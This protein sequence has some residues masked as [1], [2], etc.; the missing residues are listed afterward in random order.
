MSATALTTAISPPTSNP[1]LS[2]SVEASRSGIWVGIFAIIM[3]F[4][5][6]TSALLVRQGSGEWSHIVLPSILYANT[7]L[8]LLSS[9]SMEMSRRALARS[10]GIT[11]GV[12]TRATNT[13]AIWFAI[14]LVLGLSFVAG[15]YL[16]WRHLASQGLYLATN[17]NSSF[18]YVFTGMHALH[19]IGGIAV[20][21]YLLGL[22]IGGHTSLRRHLLDNTAIYWHFMG[23][24]W[25]Y[26]LFVIGTRL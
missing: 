14:T 22:V 19:L 21:V 5:A 13:V 24:L 25:L 20:L 1:H 8:L 12:A 11:N 15:Q 9:C 17:P 23:G 6:L 26:L 10:L 4:A 16:A 3:S 7:T 2:G 18:L